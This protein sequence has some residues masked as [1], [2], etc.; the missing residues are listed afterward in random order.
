VGGGARA[1]AAGANPVNS[2]TTNANRPEY[3]RSGEFANA[4]WGGTSR[5]SPIAAGIAALVYQAYRDTH[6]EWPTYD[7]ARDILMAGAR[8]NGYDVFTV[9]AGVLD[10]GDAV[11]TAMG[12]H[13]LSASPSAWTA[14]D[15]MG[16]VYPGFARLVAPGEERTETFSLTNHAEDDV[17]VTL[18]AQAL[19]RTSSF[20]F[21]FSTQ[22]VTHETGY[23]FSA[24]NY[25]LPIDPDTVPEGTDLMVVRAIY[26]LDQADSGVSDEDPD[27]NQTRENAWRMGVY[28]HT[29]WNDDGLIF[30]DHDGDGTV[31]TAVHDSDS[32]R[33]WGL[34]SAAEIDFE[35]SEIQRW[36]YGRIAY[37][38]ND[39]NN[40]AVLVH[41]PLERWSSGLYIALWHLGPRARDTTDFDFRIEF[42]DYD[43]AAQVELSAAELTV[44]GAGEATFDATLSVPEDAAYGAHQL[45]IFADYAR[46]EGD[47]PVFDPESPLNGGWEPEHQRLVIPVNYNVAA[48]YEWEGS[49]TLGGDDARDDESTYNN[50][51]VQGTQSWS[52]RAESGDWRFFFVNA[53]RSPRPGTLWL[54]RTSWQGA[55]GARDQWNDVDTR[56]H[57]PDHDRFSDPDHPDNSAGD[58]PE[59]ISDP[60]WYGPYS[61]SQ[62][63]ASARRLAG[64]G[65]WAFDTSSGG[66]V[67][68]LTA[69]AAS[70]L[71]LLMWH[72]VLL[73]GLQHDLP[74]ETTLSSIRVWPEA[75]TLYADGCAAV[76]VESQIDIDNFQ[77]QAFGLV[78]PISY[79]D[80]PIGQD[81]ANNP[82]TSGFKLEI[83]SDTQLGAFEIELLGRDVDDLDLFLLYDADGNGEM[84]HPQE[85]LAQSTSPTAAETIALGGVLPAGRYEVWVHGW[86]VPGGTSSFDMT[87]SAPRGDDLVAGDVPDVVSSG[88]AV[89]I[90]VCADLE[91]MPADMPD[92]PMGGVLLLGTDDSPSMFRIEV[93]W[94]REP[95][96]F[97]VYLPIA[98]FDGS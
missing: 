32:G 1:Y 93:E 2:V 44:P 95:T 13:G 45:A 56:I 85:V 7:V 23:V 19:R 46:G 68:W 78:E 8:F 41:H 58:P 72:N 40:L 12:R 50:G 6:G 94:L 42:Y 37:N 65:R 26:P 71:H 84:S 59:D 55:E 43:T 89:N 63:G 10:A 74:V 24:P 57:G 31:D 86:S 69:D 66:P 11:R 28:Q 82:A 54:A 79:D 60:S 47:E 51:A 21:E 90:E 5:S 70:G 4:T 67:D 76:Q 53:L 15:F 91:D 75:V 16:E 61:L 17:A 3:Q 34:D 22:P 30:T 29:D 87:V 33:R 88:E 25:F 81:D 80:E 49:V 20:D 27:G 96:L 73:D 98:R 83:E 52:W 14:G 18:S 9:G 38:G 64:G 97:P 92:G 35:N 48:D 39:A 36:E 62:K 77:A